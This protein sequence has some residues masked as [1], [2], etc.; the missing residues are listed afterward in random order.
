MTTTEYDL[1]IA[2]VGAVVTAFAVKFAALL[3]DVCEKIITMF[4]GVI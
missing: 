1:M 2:T 3:C 4:A